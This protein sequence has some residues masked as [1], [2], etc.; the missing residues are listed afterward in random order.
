VALPGGK[1][2]T[3]LVRT[4]VSYSFNPRVYVQALLQYN[5]RAEIWST[6]LRFGWQQTSNTGLFVVFND[7]QDLDD[8]STRTVGRSLIVKYSH[9]FDLL[10]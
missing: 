3:N 8:L 9:L 4:R 7:T 1:F 2:I 5:D 6:N 10:Q